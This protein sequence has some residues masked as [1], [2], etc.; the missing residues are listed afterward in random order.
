MLSLL[1]IFSKYNWTY[2][3][4]RRDG[5]QIFSSV[6][7]WEQLVSHT[8]KSSRDHAALSDIYTCH[9]VQRCNQINEDLQRI[10]KKVFKW[11][12]SYSFYLETLIQVNI[13]IR[14]FSFILQKCREIGYEIHE[15]VLKVLHELHTAMK[16]HHSYQTEFRT[17]E[18]KLQVCS[19]VLTNKKTL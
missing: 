18:S 2:N 15:E 16:T 12:Y 1:N 4:F 19:I 7:L 11:F 13:I 9:I 8:K 17:A 6:Q 14:E 3:N 10:Y 5:W